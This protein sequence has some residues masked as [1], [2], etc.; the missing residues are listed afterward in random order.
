MFYVILLAPKCHVESGHG[1]KPADVLEAEI[2]LKN[3]HVCRERARL[4]GRRTCFG[5]RGNIR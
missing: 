1:L 4:R 2:A 3:V 5:K